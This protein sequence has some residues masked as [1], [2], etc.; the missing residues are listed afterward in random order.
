MTKNFCLTLKSHQIFLMN[1]KKKH[2]KIS[3]NFKYCRGMTCVYFCLQPTSQKQDLKDLIFWPLLVERFWEFFKA[4]QFTIAIAIAIVIAMT[5][6]GLDMDL[7]RRLQYIFHFRD[8]AVQA[9]EFLEC[10]NSKDTNQKA[11]FFRNSLP[12]VF[13][14]I[15]KVEIYWF[16]SVF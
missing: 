11:Q 14:I 4:Q 16:Y 8:P 1:V 5:G 15:P 9:L 3:L 6:P 13:P 10:I 2:L 12:E 7:D